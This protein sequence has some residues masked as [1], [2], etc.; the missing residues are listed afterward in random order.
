MRCQ[1]HTGLVFVVRVYCGK[2]RATRIAYSCRDAQFGNIIEYA[3]AFDVHDDA[4]VPEEIHSEY[5]LTDICYN[6]I[7]CEPSSKTKVYFHRVRSVCVERRPVCCVQ[8]A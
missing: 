6:K 3:F 8:F 7:P 5:R 2:H 4:K 1:L